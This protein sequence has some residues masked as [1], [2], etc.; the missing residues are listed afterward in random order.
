[1]LEAAGRLPLPLPVDAWI[2]NALGVSRVRMLDLTPHIAMEATRLPGT[3]H[4][5]PV[6]RLLV[7]TA[8]IHDC[9]LLT[10]DQQIRHYP[11][12]VTLP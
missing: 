4:K 9:P 12:V 6:D 11:H 3:I 7:A 1:M 5:D 8:R 2:A 10:V